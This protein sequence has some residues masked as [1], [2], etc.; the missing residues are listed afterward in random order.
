M[1]LT[2]REP[3]IRNLFD[4]LHPKHFDL[5]VDATRRIAKY[6]YEKRCYESPTYALNIGTAIKQCAELAI[7]FALKRK[8]V[9][10]TI[11]TGEME[12]DFKTLIQIINSQWKYEVS[13]QAASDLSV[14]KWNKVTI[15]PLAG[16]LKLLKDFL[17]AKANAT[18]AELH[19]NND[20]IEQYRVLQ[21]VTY[22]RVIL[23]NRRRPGELQRLPV[24]IYQKSEHN[25]SYEEFGDVISPCEKVLLRKF[26]RVVVKGKRG[27][28]VPILFSTDVQAHIDVLLR[29]RQKLV[30]ERNVYLFANPNTPTEPICGYKVL[31]KYA[32]ACGARNPKAITSTKLRKHL[33]TLTQ[34][35]SMTENDMEQLANFMGHTLSVHRGSYRLP[36][37]VYQTA[38]ITKL[39]LLM[40][41]GGATEFKGK[42]LNEINIDLDEDLLEHR[43]SDGA[44]DDQPHDLSI[45]QEIDDISEFRQENATTKKARVLE[46]WTEK[47]K[48]LVLKY[49]AGHIKKKKPPKRH[50]C[51]QLRSLHTDTFINKNWLKIKV[52][53]Q[54]KYTNKLK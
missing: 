14:N 2:N 33:A 32:N 1:E 54:N 22:C 29:Y 17:T 6:D 13:S 26:R 28:G 37:D 40:E 8:N 41:K 36:D 45:V 52:F 12:A 11:Q 4:A 18:V 38:K 51:E 16:D 25:T 46:P 35:F 47:Q 31:Q 9:S 20:N 21:E 15:V 3:S 10:Q 50:E 48:H 23:L 19:R 53:V 42:T 24:H 30:S 43:D 34:L 49:F 44:L 39:L 7:V 27:R 5:I